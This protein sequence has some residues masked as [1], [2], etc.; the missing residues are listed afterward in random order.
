[1]TNYSKLRLIKCFWEISTV[2]TLLACGNLDKKSA[3]FFS[4]A[5]LYHHSCYLISAV[6]STFKKVFFDFCIF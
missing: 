3:G 6:I 4:S 1:M 5:T 2:S